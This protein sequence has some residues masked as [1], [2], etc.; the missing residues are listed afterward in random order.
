MEKHFKNYVALISEIDDLSNKLEKQHA[1]HINC[2]AGCDMCC[3]DYSIFPIEFHYILNQ[4]K[5]NKL[6]PETKE[7]IAEEDCIF[8]NNHNCSIYNARPIICRT[9]GLPLIYMNEEGDWE[10]SACELNFTAFNFEEF[11]ETNTFPQDTFNSKLFMLNKEF[12]RNFKEKKY[13]E[14]DLIPVKKLKEFI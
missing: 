8:L 11:S 9:H 5:K 3:M 13:G 1:K 2:K 10:L 14:L 4:L 12:I 6:K 7:N